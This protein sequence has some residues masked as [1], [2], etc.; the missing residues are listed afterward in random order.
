MDVCCLSRPFDNA[1]Q[2]RVALE[3]RAVLAVLKRCA[4][5]SWILLTSKM[6]RRELA[7]INNDALREDIYSL[8]PYTTENISMNKS[9]AHRAKIFKQRGIGRFDS[10]H[11]ALAESGGA[12]IFLTVDDKLLRKAKI[13]NIKLEVKNPNDWMQE[14]NDEQMPTHRLH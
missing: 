4:Q 12:D 3:S 8:F 5:G 10:I 1:Q 13:L 9:A 7:K 6:I 14:K 2:D 11:L